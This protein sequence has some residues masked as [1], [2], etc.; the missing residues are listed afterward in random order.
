[1]IAQRFFTHIARSEKLQPKQHDYTAGTR[2]STFTV[3]KE[4]V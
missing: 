1:M 3:S 2:C 4:S